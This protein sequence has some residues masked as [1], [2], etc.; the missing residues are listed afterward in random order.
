MNIEQ[1]VFEDVAEMPVLGH[2]GVP[3]DGT[4]ITFYGSDTTE[5]QRA[6]TK[7]RAAILKAGDD[8]VRMETAQIAFLVDMTKSVRG[9]E[10]D[11]SG[12]STEATVKDMDKLYALS[13]S[14]RAQAITFVSNDVNFTKG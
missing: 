14:L 1:L 13:I 11:T 7:Q 2:D 3:F 8:E 5:A 9:I 10:L 12:K 4:F 6:H